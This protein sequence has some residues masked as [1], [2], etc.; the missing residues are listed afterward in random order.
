MSQKINLSLPFNL[1][2]FIL[3]FPSSSFTSRNTPSW[4]STAVLLIFF[5]IMNVYP[6]STQLLKLCR[7]QAC[8]HRYPYSIVCRCSKNKSFFDFQDENLHME[9]ENNAFWDKNHAFVIEEKCIFWDENNQFTDE[10]LALRWK[11]SFL[12]REI[13]SRSI[14]DLRWKF[15]H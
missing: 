15:A 8:A 4:S 9:D 1:I 13:V 6:F 12:R 11:Y 5:D 14:C 3:H 2:I 7:I 10:K